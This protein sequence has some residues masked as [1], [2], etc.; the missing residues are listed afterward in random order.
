M[1]KMKD[2]LTV[3]LLA[4]EEEENLRI[5]L[6]E[7]RGFAEGLGT[8][9]EITVVDGAVA[10]DNTEA[11]CREN[12]CNYVNQRYPK[13]GGAFRT[14]IEEAGYDRFLILDADGSHPPRFIPDL[15]AAFEEGTWD[16]VIGSRYMK[17]GVTHDKGSSIAMSKLLN[18]AFRVVLGIRAKDLST[19]FRMY[20]TAELKRLDLRREN[21]DVLQEVLLKLKLQL[22]GL[23]VKE[24]PI[25]FEKRMA[26]E[27]KRRLIPFILSYIRTLFALLGLRI[28]HVREGRKA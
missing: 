5:L 11:V 13:F 26:G 2:G 24:V 27:S 12:G 17:G 22:G 1:E 8:V 23:K 4:R 18:F 14:A 6:P 15:Y 28:T 16:V 3:A 7:I 20:R 9:F 19:D 25:S 10:T 21:Y